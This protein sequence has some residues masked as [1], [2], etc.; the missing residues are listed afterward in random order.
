MR[1]LLFTLILAVAVGYSTAQ[2]KSVSISDF[3]E[4]T[5]SGPFRTTLVKSD[6]CKLEIN[7][8]ELDE[9][10]VIVNSRGGEL[11]VKVKQGLFD[12]DRYNDRGRNR[13]YATVT[14]Y[15]TSLKSIEA[16]QGASLRASETIVAE[17]MELKSS[18]GS[19]VKLDLKVQDLSLDSSMGSDVDLSGTAS[20]FELTAKMGSDVDAYL[21]KCQDVT[22]TASMGADVKV[23]AERELDASANFGASV[24]CKGNP[25]R[26][27]T[28]GTFGSDF[29]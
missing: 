3:S 16:K 27:K 12:F 26:K 2:T 1:A 18:M 21:L 24:S 20:S 6:K 22:V 4:L 13:K 14:I 9:E 10:D 8:N 11:L 15:Y 29:H 28:S 5:I 19:E 25:A 7:Y 17:R 23:F